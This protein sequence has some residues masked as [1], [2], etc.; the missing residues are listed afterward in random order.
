[1]KTSLGNERR[2]Q[3]LKETQEPTASKSIKRLE[4]ILNQLLPA[5]LAS[6]ERQFQH[7]IFRRPLRHHI[8]MQDS[9][10][11]LDSI[12]NPAPGNNSVA[13][14][15]VLLALVC[16]VKLAALVC[17]VKLAGLH[18]SHSGARGIH[19][20]FL[21]KDESQ[22]ADV[23]LCSAPGLSC[24]RAHAWKHVSGSSSSLW[25]AHRR[26]AFHVQQALGVFLTLVLA[27]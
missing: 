22:E 20:P 16:T 9:G 13:I 5:S 7:S 3:I 21:P 12:H 17:T 24:G 10:Q 11:N 19:H 25:H 27:C 4:V 1:M 6:S 2:M 26:D 23:A 14:S 8:R 15:T 18:C